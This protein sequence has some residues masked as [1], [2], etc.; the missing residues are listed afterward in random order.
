MKN[1][2]C[3][4]VNP[5]VDPLTGFSGWD[6]FVNRLF[7]EQENLQVL[8]KNCHDLKSKEERASR[9]KKKEQENNDQTNL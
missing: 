6:D 8:C 5:V 7:C 3:D 2:F 1:I 4:H 9:P